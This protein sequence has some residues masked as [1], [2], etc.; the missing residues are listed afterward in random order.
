[1]G[2]EVRLKIPQ[3]PQGGVEEGEEEEEGGEI[4]R[5]MLSRTL[6]KALL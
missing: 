4:A 1:M 3:G 5:L 6:L 2:Q